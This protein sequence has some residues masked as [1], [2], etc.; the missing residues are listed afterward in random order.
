MQVFAIGANGLFHL[1]RQFAGGREHQGTDAGTTKFVLCAAAHAEL[2]QHGQYEG[3][4]LAGAG[5]GAAQQVMAFEDQGNGL[6]LNGRRGFVTLL[7]HCLNDGRGQVQ[8]FKVHEYCAHPG[9]WEYRPVWALSQPVSQK[10]DGFKRWTQIVGLA[11]SKV[12]ESRATDA[13]QQ[14]VLSHAQG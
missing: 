13:P 4:G 11:P 6:C 12:L 14:P 9:A 7:A 5:L 8:F 1:G 2:V 3:S 10:A